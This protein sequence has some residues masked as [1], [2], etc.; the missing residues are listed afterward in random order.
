MLVITGGAGFIG[1]NIA[2]SLE[3]AGRGPIVICDRLRQGQKWRNVA[4]RRLGDVL[5]PDVLFD[6]LD[7]HGSAIAAIIHMGAVTA[8]TETNADRVIATNFKLPVRLWSWCARARVP[9][10]YA[11][12]AATYG[13]GEH[14]FD[15]DSSAEALS[16][17]RPLNLYGWSKHLFDRWVRAQ[18]DA[19]RLQPPQ[20]VG[21]KFFNVYGP[22]EAHKGPQA[23]VIAGLYPRLTSGE[24]ARL[25]ASH[26]PRFADGGQRRDF[27]WVGDCADV[28]V[29]LLD[30]PEVSG[31]FNCGTGR[32]RSFLDLAHA[33]FAAIGRTPEIEFVPTP[34]QIRDK[35]QYFTEA[36][37]DRLRAAGYDRGFTSLEDGAA[38]YIQ[39]YLATAD[40][41]R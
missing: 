28:V 40:P 11:S 19:G 15:D 23:S 6:Y 29:W 8:T 2:A 18:C 21:L 16:R 7:A 17:L 38:T 26:H 13:A 31:L 30:C 24:P 33:S 37:M 9:F 3:A 12:S 10:I 25:F 4:K 5:D 36:R 34:E 14:G 27:V 20:W 35:Y 22:N 1:S 39:C 41:Y 32:A